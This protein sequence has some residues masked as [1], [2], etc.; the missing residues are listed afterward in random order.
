[1]SSDIEVE[2]NNLIIVFECGNFHVQ[3]RTTPRFIY[4]YIY[5]YIIFTYSCGIDVV[6]V[7]KTVR[8]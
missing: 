3:I 6:A 2:T 4:I 5:I 7:K 8:W 1:M